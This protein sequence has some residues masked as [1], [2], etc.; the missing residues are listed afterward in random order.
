MH[1]S[2]LRISSKHCS[3]NSIPDLRRDTVI[4]VREFV[5]VEVMLQQGSRKKHGIV[6]GAIM[7]RQIPGVGDENAG[8]NRASAVR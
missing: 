4:S 1:R 7:D 3:E 6:M 2:A 8:Q 5:V